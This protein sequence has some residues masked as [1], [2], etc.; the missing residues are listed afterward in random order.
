MSDQILPVF[1]VADGDALVPAV[2]DDLREVLSELSAKIYDSPD[3]IDSD[4]ALFISRGTFNVAPEHLEFM[5]AGLEESDLVVQPSLSGKVLAIAVNW[6]D[7]D[8]QKIAREWASSPDQPLLQIAGAANESALE[9]FIQPP[10]YGTIDGQIGRDFA[11]QHMAAMA[12]F[13]E[14]EPLALRTLAWLINER[15]A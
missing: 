11:F 1:L 12:L 10:W 8:A 4:F 3:A 7:Q 13:P 6:S 2:N 14:S 5:M 15:L 9:I